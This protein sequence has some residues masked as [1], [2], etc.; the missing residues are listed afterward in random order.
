M[1]FQ[2]VLAPKSDTNCFVKIDKSLLEIFTIVIS[3]PRT[4]L[5]GFK[6]RFINIFLASILCL[7]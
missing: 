1:K 4:I 3:L 5:K 2:L 7:K 6:S